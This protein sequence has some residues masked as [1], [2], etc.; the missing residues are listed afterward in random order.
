MYPAKAAESDLVVPVPISFEQIDSG[1]K[2]YFHLEEN[3][4][5]VQE[6]CTIVVSSELVDLLVFVHAC[7][8]DCTF[9]GTGMTQYNNISYFI[10]QIISHNF[11]LSLP[12]YLRMSLRSARHSLRT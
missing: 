6:G 3:R 5:V 8:D 9:A 12:F 7:F 10:C 11:F 4:I 1:A 2:G